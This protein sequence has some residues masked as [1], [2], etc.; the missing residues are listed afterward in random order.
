MRSSPILR[1]VVL[2]LLAG[3]AAAQTWARPDVLQRRHQRVAL[4]AAPSQVIPLDADGDGDGDLALVLA[5]TEVDEVTQSRIEDMMEVSTVVPAMFQ[6][7]EVAWLIAEPDGFALRA[8]RWPLELSILALA[9]DGAGGLLALHDDGVGRLVRNADGVALQP[10]IEAEPSLAR[11]RQFF[12]QFRF[13][14]DV[15][16]DGLLDI[17]LPTQSGVTL[18]RGLVGGSFEPLQAIEIHEAPGRDPFARTGWIHEARVRDLDGDGRRDLLLHDR[19]GIPH[20]FLGSAD[21]RFR[22]AY[23]DAPSCRF[24][25]SAL[26][27]RSGEGYVHPAP[28]NLT[29]VD[30]DGDGR[31][32]AVV[33]QQ[34]ARDGDGLR[35]MLREV[36]R[37]VQQLRFYRLDAGLVV[38]EQPYAQVQAEGHPFD[39][40]FVDREQGALRDLD[41]D[42]RSEIVMVTLD[43]SMLQ[44]VRVLVAKSLSIGLDFHVWHQ[45]E[46]GSF[47]PVRGLDLS[48]RL[49]LNLRRLD[50]RRMAQFAGDF[51]GDGR[52]D[53]VHLG[54]GKRFTVH[55]G[56]D[57]ARYADQPDLQ[58]EL[59]RSANSLG[60]VQVRDLDG[61][62][63]AD[64]SIAHPMEARRAG[65]SSPVALDL[66]LSGGTR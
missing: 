8:E 39:L 9:H 58:V 30:L 33:L 6:R 57:G 7:R 5:Y 19:Q 2:L 18:F 20:L 52:V 17:V 27:W 54:R 51:D 41:G 46:D 61:D 47:Q 37:P 11:C 42:G 36:K 60:L 35:T 13:A 21:G 22:P 10:L 48:E 34:Q 3:T 66:Y 56:Q 1:I 53:F 45:Q 29:V 23:S 16:N 32:E 43:F 49:K 14:H 15:D 4:P 28:E 26:R 65:E 64:V 38:E 62:G 25:A 59:E 44:A 63:R 24:A 50:L 40:R 12:P 55:R 31:S